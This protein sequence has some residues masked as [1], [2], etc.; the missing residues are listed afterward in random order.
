MLYKSLKLTN[1]YL[2]NF[3]FITKTRFCDINMIIFICTNANKLNLNFFY[4]LT[5]YKYK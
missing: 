4:G 2:L 5:T 1:F 3:L